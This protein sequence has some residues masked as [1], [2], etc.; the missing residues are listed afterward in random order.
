MNI[1]K[2]INNHLVLLNIYVGMAV[3]AILAV[4]AGCAGNYG[5]LKRD[6]EV[7]QAFE[8]NQVPSNYKY[9][10][11]GDSEPYVIFGIDPKYEMESNLWRDLATD[12]EDFKHAVRF[13]WEDY[14]YYVFGA[15]ILDPNGVKVGI[16]YT[17]IRE[18]TF[19][20]VDDNKIVV[21]TAKPFLWGPEAG[22]GVRAR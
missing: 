2:K 1:L 3:I 13:M 14:N 10:Y 18:T 9:Y 17:A 15:N 4:S 8:T 16:L 11:Y 22:S 12:T 5:R 19:K 21:M 6:A 7:K 20:F